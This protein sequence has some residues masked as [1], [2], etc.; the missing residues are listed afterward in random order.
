MFTKYIRTIFL[1]TVLFLCIFWST[2]TAGEQTASH[3]ANL[4]RDFILDR[5]KD[6]LVNEKISRQA[7][8]EE[9]GTRM[10]KLKEAKKA[11]V[12]EDATIEERIA[13]ENAALLSVYDTDRNGMLSPEETTIFRTDHT[14]IYK[15]KHIIKKGEQHERVSSSDSSL[16]GVENI[17]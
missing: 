16:E 1:V 7:A 6:K 12:A 15:S 2:C 10:E 5:A 8:E 3:E 9:T 14:E 17:E 11:F 4:S 13:A